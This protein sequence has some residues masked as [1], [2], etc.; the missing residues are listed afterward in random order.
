[1]GLLWAK[2]RNYGSLSELFPPRWICY[3]FPNQ[4]LR[5]PNQNA[6]ALA[7]AHFSFRFRATQKKNGFYT[8]KRLNYGMPITLDQIVEETGIG[9]P[10]TG[11]RIA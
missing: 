7:L 6:V 9:R 3:N 1:M 2:K 10:E 5:A 11:R 8:A 4:T